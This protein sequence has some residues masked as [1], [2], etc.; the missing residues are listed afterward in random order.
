ML[1]PRLAVV[2]RTV[3]RNVIA[4]TECVFC[5]TA[6]DLSVRLHTFMR[7]LILKLSIILILTI[8]IYQ[9]IS[10]IQV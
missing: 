6:N 4:A 7:Y 5:R 10:N 3:P 8:L 2:Q 1:D 9:Y